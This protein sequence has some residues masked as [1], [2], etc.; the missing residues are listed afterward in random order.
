MHPL[1]AHEL[2]VLAYDVAFPTAPDRTILSNVQDSS[3]TRGAVLEICPYS[4]RM[5][6]RADLDAPYEW[7]LTGPD[8]LQSTRCFG[9][10]GQAHRIARYWV[11][12]IVVRGKKPSTAQLD[13]MWARR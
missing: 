1:S 8:G 4:L 9:T 11:V 7:Q 13:A 10:E 5:V 6:D 3:G 2:L 12:E